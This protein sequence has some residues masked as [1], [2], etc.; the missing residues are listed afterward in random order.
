MAA[1]T[2]RCARWIEHKWKHVRG[3]GDPSFVT[4]IVDLTPV[5]DGAG[6][7]RLLDMVPGRSAAAFSGWLRKR[8]PAFRDRAKVVSMDG[9]AGYHSA[10]KDPLP[11]A[12]TV[13]DPFHVL[14]LAAE[15]LTVCRQRV[16]QAALGHR[17]RPGDPLYGIKRVLL[18]RKT[19]RTDKQKE[20]QSLIHSGQLQDR[21]NAL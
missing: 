7:A 20:R 9:F 19:L 5:I 15:K 16:Q 14:H 13:M 12:R 4:V 1:T 18:T 6:T 21:I 10:A 8:D 3:Q 2:R 17:G 11:Q